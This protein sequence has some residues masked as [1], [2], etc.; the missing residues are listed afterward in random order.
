[1]PIDLEKHAEIRVLDSFGVSY[2]GIFM[3]TSKIMVLYRMQQRL[4]RLPSVVAL[5]Y[6]GIRLTCGSF[7]RILF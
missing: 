4:G 1:M 5:L 3:Q 7:Y 2:L 6:G